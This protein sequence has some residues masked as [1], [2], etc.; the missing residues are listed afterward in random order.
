MSKE[1]IFW[2]ARIFCAI[3]MT[4]VFAAPLSGF[5]KDDSE[6]GEMKA[7]FYRLDK[8]TYNKGEFLGTVEIKGGDYAINVSDAPLEDF[9][10]EAL[11]EPLRTFIGEIKDGLAIEKE[12]IL[13]PG[14]PEHL[15][16]VIDKCWKEY[17]II[18]EIIREDSAAEEQ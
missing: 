1:K 8:E 16:L 7:E 11:K 6:G 9:L 4:V 14:T 3:I 12:I 18:G 5:G 15:E 2:G 17:R 10:R 13:E